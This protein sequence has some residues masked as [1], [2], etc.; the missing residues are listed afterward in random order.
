MIRISTDEDVHEYDLD[1]IQDYATA[2][3]DKDQYLMSE[4]LYLTE[5]RMTRECHCF[6]V[7]CVCGL[8]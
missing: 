8:V 1:L 6:S 7:N 5:Q 3:F 2:L 4:V